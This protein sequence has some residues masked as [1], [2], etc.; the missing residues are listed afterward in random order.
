MARNHTHTR[1]EEGEH[2]CTLVRE[3]NRIKVR[4]WIIVMR[5]LLSEQWTVWKVF[6]VVI[7][8]LLYIY[9]V[10]VGEAKTIYLYTHIHAIYALFSLTLTIICKVNVDG[11]ANDKRKSHFYGHFFKRFEFICNRKYVS[12]TETL[13]HYRNISVQIVRL[14]WRLHMTLQLH[15]ITNSTL[16]IMIWLFHQ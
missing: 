14:N 11:F 12:F 9:S 10:C 4:K 1:V 2:I 13:F 6:C 15:D 16:W 3:R 5:Q 8:V 7:V